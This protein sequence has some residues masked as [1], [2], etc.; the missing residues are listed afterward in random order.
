MKFGLAIYLCFTIYLFNSAS[1][2]FARRKINKYDGTTTAVIM[3]VELDKDYLMSIS[4]LDA[5]RA[6]EG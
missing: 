1:C 2:L 5:D 6:R 3:R 4:S